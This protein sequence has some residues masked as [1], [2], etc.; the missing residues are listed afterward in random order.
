MQTSFYASRLSLENFC[1][2]KLQ[3]SACQER[4]D[5]KEFKALYPVN[6]SRRPFATSRSLD[7]ACL[8]PGKHRPHW[9]VL[10]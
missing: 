8:L 3:L 4:A 10:D 7:L 2:P 1:D 6:A 9:S 5:I